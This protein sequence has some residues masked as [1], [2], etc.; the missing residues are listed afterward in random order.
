MTT[1]FEIAPTAIH[2]GE[3]ELPFVTAPDSTRIQLLQ[4]DLAAGVWV[5]RTLFP[6][7]VTVQTHKHTGQVFAFTTTGSWHY[8]ESPEAVNVAGSY[9]FEPAGSVHTL[10]VPSANEQVTDAWFVIHGANLNLTPEGAVEMVIDAAGM[11]AVYRAM[12]EAE[13]GVAD[14]PVVVVG[15][16]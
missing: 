14:P 1:A 7:G 13:H 9:L 10:H 8:L 2:R 16:E 12:C 3:D 4:V 6:P 11:L 15:T 5:V